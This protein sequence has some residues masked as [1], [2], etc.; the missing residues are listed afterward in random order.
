M[1]TLLAA[2]ATA[3]Y[4]AGYGERIASVDQS[5]VREPQ[6]D[7]ASKSGENS[8]ERSTDDMAQAQAIQNHLDENFGIPG[9]ATDWYRYITGVAVQGDTV[10]VQTSLSSNGEMAQGVCSGTSS[11]V[12]ANQNSSA[13]LE[14]VQVLGASGEVLIDRRGIG[15]SCS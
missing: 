15:D 4:R 9:F 2:L 11:Y 6:A 12:F 3:P 14:N 8:S 10:K 7:T 5:S 13:G 1:V